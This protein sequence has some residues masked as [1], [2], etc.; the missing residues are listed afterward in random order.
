L[1]VHNG[2]QK[3]CSLKKNMPVK[4]PRRKT[5]YD[6]ILR[7]AKDQPHLQKNNK[8]FKPRVTRPNPEINQKKFS[9][10]LYARGMG[11][12]WFAIGDP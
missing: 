11:L 9:Q 8:D 3:L 6:C 4:I 2:F 7:R 12:G 5:Q 10:A 1:P